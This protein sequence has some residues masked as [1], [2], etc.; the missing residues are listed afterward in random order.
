MG[1]LLLSRPRVH[2]KTRGSLLLMGG[3]LC[4]WCSQMKEDGA[5]EV[6]APRAG[7]GSRGVAGHGQSPR[8]GQWYPKGLIV[9]LGYRSQSVPP[10]SRA[11]EEGLPG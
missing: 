1:R 9:S 5:L 11:P 6:L 4:A 10:Q 3:T 8:Q 7:L 2:C